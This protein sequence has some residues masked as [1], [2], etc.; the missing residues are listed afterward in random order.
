VWVV[1][2]TKDP[3]VELHLDAAKSNLNE[4]LHSSQE[5][6]ALPILAAR[7]DEDLDAFHDKQYVEF[8]IFMGPQFCRTRAFRVTVLKALHRRNTLED[9]VADATSHSWWFLS[10]MFGMN[11]GWS[12]Y[13]Q[14]KVAKQ[15]VLIN[16]TGLPLLRQ[17]NLLSTF[18]R[19]SH[20]QI[21]L[22]LSLPTSTIRFRRRLPTP[23][24][25]QIASI[26]VNIG[27]M[28]P[29]SWNS[30]RSRQLRP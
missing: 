7:A 10:Y 30:T 4:N 22:R 1:S 29:P 20:T 19:V 25:I 9:K 15:A 23:S 5:R 6:A 13:S 18:I 14:R 8:V 17:N 26:E 3:K 24:M 11:L 16:D 21:S 28:K 2:S 12:L 27:L